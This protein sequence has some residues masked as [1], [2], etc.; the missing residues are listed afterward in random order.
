MRNES[1]SLYSAYS[2]RCKTPEIA[3]QKLCLLSEQA[4]IRVVQIVTLYAQKSQSAREWM[5]PTIV[6]HLCFVIIVGIFFK[7]QKNN[8]LVELC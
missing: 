1:E 3:A 2:P 4:N 5:V 7:V 8:R 6:A